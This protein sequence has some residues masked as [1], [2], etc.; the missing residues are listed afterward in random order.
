[1]A[2]KVD[3]QRW[4]PPVTATMASTGP[5]FGAVFAVSSLSVQSESVE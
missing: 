2:A 5:G 3:G 4:L 1:M